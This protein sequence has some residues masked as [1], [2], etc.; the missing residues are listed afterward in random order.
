MEE[1][2]VNEAVTTEVTEVC[3]KLTTADKWKVAGVVA[4]ILP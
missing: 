2:M 4:G 1:N 3:T